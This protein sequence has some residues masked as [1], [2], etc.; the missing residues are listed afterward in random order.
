MVLGDLA[1]RRR[2]GGLL[3]GSVVLDKTDKTDTFSSLIRK[4]SLA[5]LQDTLLLDTSEYE[6]ILGQLIN[7]AARGLPAK[8]AV[9][10]IAVRIKRRLFYCG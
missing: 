9:C 5:Y 6:L 8:L 2:E 4:V 3:G 10:K 1:E 7:P